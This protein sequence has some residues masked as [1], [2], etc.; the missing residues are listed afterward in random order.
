MSDDVL[1]HFDTVDS[2]ANVVQLYEKCQHSM[3]AGYLIEL[4]RPVSS[5]VDRQHLRSADCCQ[6]GLYIT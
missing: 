3:A 5:I 6:L 2:V 4:C 1:S